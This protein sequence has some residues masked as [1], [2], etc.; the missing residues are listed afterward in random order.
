MIDVISD[1]LPR[2]SLFGYTTAYF[3]GVVASFGAAIERVLGMISIALDGPI[4]NGRVWEK[5]A[6]VVG[7]LL[8]IC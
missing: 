3:Q 2:L 8:A 4:L 6:S 5:F 1:S 7:K